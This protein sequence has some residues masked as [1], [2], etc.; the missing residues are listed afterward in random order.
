[1]FCGDLLCSRVIKDINTDIWFMWVLQILTNGLKVEVMY[2]PLLDNERPNQD[3]GA[4]LKPERR[5]LKKDFNQSLIQGLE[6]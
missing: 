4:F 5:I 1:M 2:M 3:L 6:G